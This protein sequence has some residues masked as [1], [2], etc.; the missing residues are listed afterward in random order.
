[1]FSKFLNVLFIVVLSLLFLA[2]SITCYKSVTAS[3][4]TEYCYIDTNPRDGGMSLMAYRSWRPDRSLGMFHTS[5][6]A[7]AFAEEIK[8]PIK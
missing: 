2:L 4:N 3:G 7:V 1:M 8:C 6:E 5:R